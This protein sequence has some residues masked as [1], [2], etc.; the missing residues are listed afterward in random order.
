[1][2]IEAVKK[3]QSQGKNAALDALHDELNAIKAKQASFKQGKQGVFDEIKTIDQRIAGRVKDIQAARAK[4]PARSPEEVEKRIEQLED[5]VESGQLRILDEKKALTEIS[6]LKKSKTAFTNIAKIEEAIATDRA[7]VAEIRASIDDSESK[8]LHTRAGEII[9]EI[10]GHRAEKQKVKKSRDELYSTRDKAFEEKHA[11]NA[12]L[13][14]L[15]D[16]YYGKLKAYQ[17]QYSADMAVR[18]E[19]EKEERQAFEKE[20]RLANAKAKLESAS[21]PAYG[22]EIAETENLLGFFEG[23]LPS[24]TDTS[25]ASTPAP[26][27]A[28]DDS[29][30]IKKD[31]GIFMEGTGGKRSKKRGG[32]KADK[33]NLNLTVIESL[34]ALNIGIPGSKSD[35][36]TVV[37]QLRTKLN[38]Y[39]DNQ[40]RV[41][42]ENIAKAEADIAKA[43]AEVE[44]LQE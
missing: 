15:R 7:A 32:S 42:K 30:V 19:K 11:A 29:K 10:D 21:T 18:R 12:E 13:Q 37:E 17:D 36:P 20:K 22:I 23:Q 25:A 26:T 14:A 33:F 24:S 41:T 2:A 31:I 1:M 16:E 3:T 4:L 28:K 38:H 34:S 44:A 43:E 5:S 27:P 8:A 9:K 40:D 6:Q 35:V 39:K